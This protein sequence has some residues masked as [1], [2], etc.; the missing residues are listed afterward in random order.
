MHRLLVIAAAAAALLV[1]GAPPALAQEAATPTTTICPSRAEAMGVAVRVLTPVI[2][3]GATGAIEVSA[4]KGTFLR[5]TERHAGETRYES[6][7]SS[8]FPE[9]D[10]RFAHRF[11]TSSPTTAAYEVQ[12]GGG[13]PNLWPGCPVPYFDGATYAQRLVIEA[14]TVLTLRVER[15]GTRAYHF[16]GR[17]AGH[18]R[19]VISLYRTDDRGRSVLTA[20]TRAIGDIWTLHRVFLGSG[21]YDFHASSGADVWN[22]AGRSETRRVTIR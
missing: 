2:Q 15:T 10:G 20:Q 6:I 11:T 12:F 5:L 9:S 7:T 22:A 8:I 19:D 1:A 17:H 18:D 3:S 14:A 13:G 16:S 4:P 21:T